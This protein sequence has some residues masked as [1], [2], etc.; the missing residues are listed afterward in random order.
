M[1]DEKII[2]YSEAISEKIKSLTEYEQAMSISSY[3]AMPEE[4]QTEDIIKEALR[5]G[6]KV[7]V[8]VIPPQGRALIFSE[9]FDFSELEPG[10]F[11][12]LEPR[13]ESLRPRMLST[14]QIA[15]VPMVAW[16]ERGFRLGHGAGYY[17]MAL[18]HL[19]GTVTIGLGFEVQRVYQLPTEPHDV[20]LKMIVTERRILRFSD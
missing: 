1:G 9:L 12:I 2:E 3:V 11:G 15:L 14:A 18:A 6:K 16:D 7:L 13:S 19:K 8:P 20:R 17:D 5:L 4:V 10:H